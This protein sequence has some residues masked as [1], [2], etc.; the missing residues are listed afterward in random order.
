MT[1]VNPLIQLQQGC[2]PNAETINASFNTLMLACN[3]VITRINAIKDKLTTPPEFNI[4]IEN[5][6]L[7][8]T[9]DDVTY[10]NNRLS[11]ARLNENFNKFKL[12]LLTIGEVRTL[13]GDIPFILEDAYGIPNK[14]TNLQITG[15]TKNVDNDV[16]IGLSWTDNANNEDDFELY[17]SLVTHIGL[18]TYIYLRPENGGIL[19]ETPL[20]DATTTVLNVGDPFYS[21][22]IGEYLPD[23]ATY[24]S[25]NNDEYNFA[26][27]AVN[28]VGV[29][30]QSNAVYINNALADWQYSIDRPYDLDVTFSSLDAVNGSCTA[31][32]DF[33]QSHPTQNRL[34]YELYRRWAGNS[35]GF[36]IYPVSDN[37]WEKI[38]ESIGNIEQAQANLTIENIG[39]PDAIYGDTS[40]HDMLNEYYEFKLVAFNGL[41]RSM[42]LND[43]MTD[44]VRAIMPPKLPLNFSGQ[45]V[46]N[47]IVL[48]WDKTN[49]QDT[50]LEVWYST[51]DIDYIKLSTS[52]EE[53]WTYSNQIPISFTHTS[54]PDEQHYYKIRAINDSGDTGLS[55]PWSFDS[56]TEINL[57]LDSYD[58]NSGYRWTFSWEFS[59]NPDY[60]YLYRKINSGSYSPVATFD[61]TDRERVYTYTPSVGNTYTFVLTAD[62]GGVETDPSNEVSKTI[63]SND[64]ALTAVTG[65]GFT[66]N[67]TRLTWSRKTGNL[68]YEIYSN[69][70]GSTTYT[71]AGTVPTNQ[72]YFDVPNPGAGDMNYYKVRAI[73]NVK[74]AF[75]LN[76]SSYV[77][78][79]LRPAPSVSILSNVDHTTYHTFSYNL[80]YN[81]NYTVSDYILAKTKDT[82]TGN[83]TGDFF[84]SNGLGKPS[85][86][87]NTKDSKAFIA[88]NYPMYFA[89]KAYIPT[90]ANVYGSY[91]SGSEYLPAPNY[92]SEIIIQNEVP[93]M[94]A[95]TFISATW[96][97]EYHNYVVLKYSHPSDYPI[98]ISGYIK[99]DADPNWG[100]LVSDSQNFNPEIGDNSLPI[101]W[102]G[103]NNCYCGLS[104]GGYTT[105]TFAITIQEP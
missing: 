29:S 59:G 77:V 33:Y 78:E 76:P 98:V 13:N 3:D 7:F 38:A 96:D 8:G 105:G 93:D 26:I 44:V 73:N 103:G 16:L 36:P 32:F 17:Q 91:L 81:V 94:V 22:N 87:P 57:S 67:H 35:L 102:S 83:F 75:S 82:P 60:F 46:D 47:D 89:F 12:A 41:S 95:P 70:N 25:I 100:G 65:L 11:A 40:L 1:Q 80:G 31:S 10:D 19:I 18:N 55:E 9:V 56:T 90:S 61:G 63:T 86:N 71:L 34:G 4:I 24:F 58:N 2:A 14:P 84:G 27:R 28:T 37:T 15:I 52:G 42:T 66:N 53:G 92:S 21:I 49:G 54:P 104:Y 43:D 6:N 85:T 97:S 74:G 20:A 39:F 5:L 99:P 79:G 72:E 45:F 101:Y 51:D 62:I 23:N 69:L 48:T 64:I 68:G 30:A 88:G 50:T